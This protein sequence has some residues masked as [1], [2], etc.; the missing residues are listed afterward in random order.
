MSNSRRD[1]LKSLA[2]LPAMAAA[3]AAYG[4][5]KNLRDDV[6]ETKLIMKDRKSI[7]NMKNYAAPAISN[8][9]VGYIG[10]GNRG[11]ASMQ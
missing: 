10:M 4:V 8:I 3:A 6:E 5:E 9:R 1:F 11:R 2:G 7:F